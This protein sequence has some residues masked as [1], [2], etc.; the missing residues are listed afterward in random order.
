MRDAFIAA[1][2]LATGSSWYDSIE[3]IAIPTGF[4]TASEW[5]DYED[6]PNVYLTVLKTYSG[7]Q[8]GRQP[9]FANIANSSFDW[10]GHYATQQGF[11]AQEA[12]EYLQT[13]IFGSVQFG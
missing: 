8:V 13:G 3:F 10:D 4:V 6:V 7:Y 1:M 9:F 5:F 2:N 12:D 11:T